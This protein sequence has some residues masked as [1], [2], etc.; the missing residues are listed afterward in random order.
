MKLI[1]IGLFSGIISG[2]GIGGGVIL[3]PS[4]VLFQDLSQL[5]AQGVNLF[6]FI[7]VSI[8]A[9]L[10]HKKEGNLDVKKNKWIIV[11]GLVGALIGAIIANL[12]EEDRLRTY[13]GIFLLLIGILELFKKNKPKNV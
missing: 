12:I 7:P 10:T 1:L 5:T 2:M 13:F 8:I 6:V 4:L 3:I 9:L 11:G